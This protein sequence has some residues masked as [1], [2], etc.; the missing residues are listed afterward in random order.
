MIGKISRK[1]RCCGVE[2]YFEAKDKV[3]VCPYCG[4]GNERPRSEKTEAIERMDYANERLNMGEFKEADAAFREALQACPEENEA[5]WGM[6]LCKY[7]VMYVESADGKE[8]VITCRRARTS[9]FQSEPDYQIVLEQAEPEVR[10]AY[11]KDAEYID[12]VQAEIRRLQAQTKPYDVFLC[13]KETTPEGGRTEDSVIA[14]NI[15]NDLTHSGYRVF[16]APVSLNETTGYNYEAAIFVAIEKSSVMLVIGTLKEYFNSTWVR[17]EW[18]RFLD[19]IDLGDEKLLLPLFRNADDLPDEFK[20]RFIQGYPM[21]GPYMLDVKTRINQIIQ[22]GPGGGEEDPEIVLARIY[23]MQGEYQEAKNVL[24]D[25]L[26]KQ[27]KNAE[28]WLLK[29]MIGLRIREESDFSR[30]EQPLSENV[31]FMTALDFA[32]GEFRERLEGYLASAGIHRVKD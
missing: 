14:H 15:Y 3:K 10:A 17:S 6:L 30:V 20:N 2:I 7:G 12:R 29:A 28:I 25:K 5:R 27:P 18:R 9:S 21:E 16:F 13:Y 26:K 31:E 23:I 11:K 4:K 22:K 32:A 8:R 19:R 24:N 1:C